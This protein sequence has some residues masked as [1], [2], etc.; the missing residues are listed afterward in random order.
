MEI[1]S[2]MLFVLNVGLFM[3]LLFNIVDGYKSGFI[4]IVDLIGFILSGLLAWFIAPYIASTFNFLPE[5]MIPLQGTFAFPII[6]R[7][8]NRFI[9]FT[10]LFVLLGIALRLLRKVIYTL[11]KIKFIGVANKAFGIGF[12]I[13]QTM[14][15]YVIISFLLYTPLFSNGEQAIQESLLVCSKPVTNGIINFTQGQLSQLKNVSLLIDP[16]TKISK[17]KAD[18]IVKYFKEQGIEENIVRDYINNLNNQITNK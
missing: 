7:L 6:Y 3:L 17:D 5:G 2:I 16:V 4:K 15:I 10:V 13:A 11:C 12:G 14:V 9:I 8:F 18:E 1:T